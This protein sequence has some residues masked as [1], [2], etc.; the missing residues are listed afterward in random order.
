[1]IQKDYYMISR[2]ILHLWEAVHILHFFD[3]TIGGAARIKYQASS[4]KHQLSSINIR[5]PRWGGGGNAKAESPSCLKAC[6]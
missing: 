5:F 4:I 6:A 3:A 1:M 2:L